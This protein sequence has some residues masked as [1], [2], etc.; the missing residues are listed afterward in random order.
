MGRWVQRFY[1]EQIQAGKIFGRRAC[2]P[3]EDSDSMGKIEM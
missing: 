3:G 1:Q 2:C